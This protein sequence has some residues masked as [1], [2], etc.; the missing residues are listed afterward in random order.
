MQEVQLNDNS[1]KIHK[2]TTNRDG[3]SPWRRPLF[4]FTQVWQLA[5]AAA[6]GRK[7]HYQEDYCI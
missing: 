6:L 4:R 3:H 1:T 5:P 7:G 2:M